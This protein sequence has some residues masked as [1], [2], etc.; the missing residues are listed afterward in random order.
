MFAQEVE[1][2][3]SMRGCGRAGGLAI[4]GAGAVLSEPG[5]RTISTGLHLGAPGHAATKIKHVRK[6]CTWYFEVLKF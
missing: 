6:A 4:P 3:G 5:A 2:N 1:F